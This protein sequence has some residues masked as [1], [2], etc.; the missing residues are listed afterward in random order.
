MSKTEQFV[1]FAILFIGAVGIAVLNDF[2][3]RR[4]ARKKSKQLEPGQSDTSRTQDSPRTDWKMVVA[5]VVGGPL[6]VYLLMFT[7]WFRDVLGGVN[8]GLIALFIFAI[9]FLVGSIAF[10]FGRNYWRQRHYRQALKLVREGNPF[11][12]IGL[13]QEE[14]QSRGPS[15][16]LLNAVVMIYL[17]TKE[18]DNALRACDELEAFSPNHWIY[19]NNRG[20]ALR[21]RG[22]L[23][24][25]LES[26][27]QAH[28]LAPLD[29]NVA[30]NYCSQLARLGEVDKA[31][32]A[33][34]E[35]EQ[36]FDK[37]IFL[38]GGRQAARQ[39]YVDRLRLAIAT[40]RNSS[41]KQH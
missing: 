25:A 3:V 2:L 20:V 18:W 27:R 13:L 41:L 29:L 17:E 36:A 6:I 1:I 34:A 35:A 12:A 8:K 22:D 5:L 7:T 11:R 26:F 15:I 10:A 38:F 32:S 14:L 23:A 28:A 21:E 16:D 33:L 40:A 37:H 31:E 24:E 4:S 9:V 39:Q 30:F 19:H